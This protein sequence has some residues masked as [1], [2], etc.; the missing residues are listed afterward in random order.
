M[1]QRREKVETVPVGNIV[2][3]EGLKNLKSGESLVDSQ[4]INEMVPFEN[5][6]YVTTAV[7]TVSIEPESP[8]VLWAL[9]FVLQSQ[10]RM[11]EAVEVLELAVSIS[12]SYADGY[13]LLAL[14][15]NKLADSEEAIRLIE[16]G[17]KLN[18]YYTWDYLYNLGRAYYALGDYS[19]AGQYLEQAIQRNEAAELPRLF[20]IANYIQLGQQDDAEWEVTEIE[21]LESSTTLSHLR[22]GTIVVDEDLR[23]QFF[24]DLSA[25]GLPE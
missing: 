8:H 22:R 1:G 7:I 24:E 2:A 10:N 13:A 19:K 4:Y 21:M 12:P 11:D 17:M 15:K 5:V 20:L 16:K 9:G 25:A 3:L 14:I 23:K 6:K 18:P